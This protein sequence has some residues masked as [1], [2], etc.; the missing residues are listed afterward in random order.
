MSKLSM[1]LTAF[2]TGFV[3]CQSLNVASR[4]SRRRQL[5]PSVLSMR[6][7]SGVQYDYDR[8]RRT[9]W[10]DEMVSAEMARRVEFPTS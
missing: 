7:L 10:P 1:S 2:V 9:R 3:M 8:G 4:V 5:H 6:D